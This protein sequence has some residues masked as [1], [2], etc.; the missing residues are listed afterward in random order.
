[1][2]VQV[3][4]ERASEF[5][6]TSYMGEIDISYQEIVDTLGPPTDDGDGYKVDANWLLLFDNG[7]VATIYNY[8][9]GI[10]Y[11]GPEGDPVEDI[12]DWHIGGHDNRA[13]DLVHMLLRGE[14]SIG[15][16]HGIE[17]HPD[18]DD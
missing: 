13:V 12:R 18:P 4:D 9:D 17:Y 7:T 2:D 3:A 16:I 14:A 10:N 5:G 1:M 8:K 6:G 15:V 11:C